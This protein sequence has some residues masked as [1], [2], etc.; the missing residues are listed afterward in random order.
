MPFDQVS[1]IYYRKK[2]SSGAAAAE[3]VGQYIALGISS[4]DE[5]GKKKAKILA[6]QHSKIPEKYLLTLVQVTNPTGQSSDEIAALLSKHFAKHPWTERLNLSH[7]IAQLPDEELEGSAGAVHQTPG[8]RAR[9]AQSSH[10]LPGAA[11]RAATNE[12]VDLPQAIQNINDA[13]QARREAAAYASQLSRKGGSNALYR[14]A[15]VVYRERVNEHARQAQHMTST[16]ADLLVDRSST[17]NSIDLHG[18]TVRDGVRIAKNRTQSWWDN[19]GEYRTRRAKEQPFIVITGLGRH[20]ASGVSQ[21]R[22]SVAAA[23][24]QDGWKVQIET[25]KFFISGRR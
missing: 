23:L 13:H 20:S 7:R 4:E 19:L 16:A 21:L 25:G 8:T 17:N 6:S 2:C 1:D 24:L 22:Q 3:I 10:K 14:Q 15:A 11:S 5:E 12:P 18:V 9:A